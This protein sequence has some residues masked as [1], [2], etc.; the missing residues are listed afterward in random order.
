[1]RTRHGEAFD[2]RIGAIVLAAPDVDLDVFGRLIDRFGDLRSRVTV[3]V[4]SN[5]RALSLSRRL[6][7]NARVGIADRAVL[8]AYGIRVADA[9]DHGSGLARHDTFMSN[10]EVRAVVKR[11]IERA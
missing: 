8:E 2:E 6:A 7:G 4:A 9:T 1:M 3:I 5:D 10:A 11:A